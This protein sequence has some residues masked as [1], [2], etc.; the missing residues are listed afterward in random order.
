MD[1]KEA[2]GRLFERQDLT[3]QEMV[4]VMRQVMTGA[5]TDAQ[6]GALLASLRMKSESI[7]EI[8]GAALVMRDLVAKVDLGDE[9]LVDLCGTGGDGAN[10]FNVSTAASLV[11]AAAGVRVA[12]HGNRSVSSSTGSADVL[13]AAGVRLD[14]TPD[15]VARCIRE[16]HLGF[17]FAP[18]HHAAMKYAIK[19]RREIGQ[20]TIFNILGPL[21]NPAGAKRQVLGV[22]NQ[23][24]CKPLAEVL[25]RLGSEHVLVVHADDGL[26]EISMATTTTVAELKDGKVS[27]YRVQ[28]EDFG[29]ESQSLVGLAVTNAT[30]S[31]ELIRSALGKSGE[32]RARKAAD[33]IALNAGAAIY[34]SGLA[35]TL[36]EGVLMAEDAIGSGLARNKLHELVEFTRALGMV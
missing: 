21:T 29:I 8:T 1:I 17:M 34:V 2:L 7:D 9:R 20:R 24:L 30:E 28:P 3:Q 36:K 27:V 13:E 16:I 19:P 35:A 18:G 4:E 5:A 22:F 31:L 33:I 26:D 15:Q 25:M 14:L 6:I 11:A 10:L 32:P 12:K 23:A